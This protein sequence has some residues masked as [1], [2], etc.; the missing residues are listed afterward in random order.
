MSIS[1]LDVESFADDPELYA[2]LVEYKDTGGRMYQNRNLKPDQSLPNKSPIRPKYYGRKTSNSLRSIRTQRLMTQT[3]LA[4][5]S[6]T[7]RRT[8]V[9]IENSRREPSVYLALSLAQ[10]LSVQVQDI[11]HL[12]YLTPVPPSRY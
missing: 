11:F 2:F 8:I 10:A 12:P 6:G 1:D 9:A 7:T 3:E 5:R 4:G